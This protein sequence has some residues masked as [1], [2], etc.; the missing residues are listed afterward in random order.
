MRY[1]LL[2]YF[3]FILFNPIKLS[4]DENYPVWLKDNGKHSDQTSGITFIG[5]K[6][7]AK[8][9]LVCDDIGKI[10]R[11][12]LKND[13]IDIETIEFDK[14]VE[15]YLDK[16]EKQDFEEIVY[17]KFN[18]K[19]YL[20]IEGNGINYRNEVGI[21]E[22]KFKN[23]DVFNNEI[24]GISK[25]EFPEW[26]EIAK[27]T[28]KNLGFEGVAVSKTKIFLGLE[29]FQFGQIFLD[30]TML[31]V[32]DKQSKKLV[33]E[34]S[35]KKLGIHTICGLYAL[36]DYNIYGIDRNQQSFFEIRFDE[37]YNPKSVELI[38][39]DLPVPGKKKLKYVAS[40]ESISLDD[41]NNVYVIDDPWKKFYIPQDEVFNQL[42]KEDQENF[43][44]FIPLLFKYKLN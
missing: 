5:A 37:M 20:S 39:L 1:F 2:I 12:K 35:T 10:H 34:I 15:K 27:F 14:Q 17:D 3:L 23:N 33:R 19:V 26:E 7:N 9:F 38:K 21:Y 36:D 4:L 24:T 44:K 25:I 42:N 6:N 18:N 29:G 11:I 30:S 8:Y 31:Y 13:K 28:D 43:K 40:I 41:E 22:I 16:F 32:I